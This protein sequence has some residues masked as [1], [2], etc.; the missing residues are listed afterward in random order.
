MDMRC[1]LQFSAALHPRKVFLLRIKQ[2]VPCVP[3]LS[4]W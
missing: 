2:K 4:S 3:K 1:Q